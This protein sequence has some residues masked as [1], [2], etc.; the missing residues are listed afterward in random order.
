M[1]LGMFYNSI[2]LEMYILILPN[3]KI[4]PFK[5][6]CLDLYSSKLCYLKI[7]PKYYP[8]RVHFVVVCFFFF[9]VMIAI[10][11]RDLKYFLDLYAF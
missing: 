2:V 5:T 9:F 11:E 8:S 7:L 10:N 3:F 1:V 4:I 6:S